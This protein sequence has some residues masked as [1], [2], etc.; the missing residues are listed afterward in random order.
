MRARWALFGTLSSSGFA[1]DATVLRSL[2]RIQKFVLTCPEPS[3]APM[4]CGSR[5]VALDLLFS[6]PD[7][8][9]AFHWHGWRRRISDL[10]LFPRGR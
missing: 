1:V 7:A 8:C 10:R 4:T 2:L 9:S 5:L 3:L 6:T